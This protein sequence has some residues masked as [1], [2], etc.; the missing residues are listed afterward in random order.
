M[1]RLRAFWVLGVVVFAAAAVGAQDGE[2]VNVYAREAEGKYVVLA[3]NAYVIPVW[4]SVG[5][6][7][8]VNMKAS[9]DIPY[10]ALVPAGA[11]GQELFTLEALAVS[12][13]RGYRMAIAY[14]KGDPAAAR[15]DEGCLYLFPFG[16]GTKHRV[17]Q[18]YN[19]RFTHQDG[20]NR[21]ALDFDLAMNTPVFAA[22]GGLVF[23]VKKNSTR[24]GM[25]PAYNK[26]ANFISV[27]HDDGTVGNYIHLKAGGALVGPG[28]RVEAG[29]LIGYSGNTGV[30]S[31]PHLHFDVQVPTPEGRMRSIPVRFLNYDGRAVEAREGGYY[32]AAHPGKPDF[33]AVFGSDLR[34][35]DFRGYSAAAALTGKV[36]LRFELIDETYTVFVRNG[37]DSAKEVVVDFSLRNLVPSRP[38]PL[39]LTVPAL[40]ERFL[41][42]LR[43]R[44]GA[45]GWEYG[46]SLRTKNVP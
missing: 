8:L 9:V 16:H 35:E 45:T 25:S 11:R 24:G 19:G 31:G 10:R 13:R 43:A 41:L 18:G 40:A 7:S 21:Y 36:E 6:P 33:Q 46:Y 2:K 28:D 27:L 1:R 14:A 39:S 38:E 34:E 30:S 22:R 44:P 17:T 32:Y 4:I 3:D 23:D 20:E 15:P 42:L 12:G 29:Q 5:F 37:T 26:D